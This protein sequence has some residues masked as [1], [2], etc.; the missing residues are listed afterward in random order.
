MVGSVHLILEFVIKAAF[1]DGGYHIVQNHHACAVAL[2]VK[3][4]IAV[5]QEQDFHALRMNL[6][7]IHI[8]RIG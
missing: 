3:Q 4:L 5:F 7:H 1:N 8:H 6:G 2:F